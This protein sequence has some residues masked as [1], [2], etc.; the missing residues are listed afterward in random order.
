MRAGLQ[1]KVVECEGISKYDDPIA[2]MRKG[3][4]MDAKSGCLALFGIA[5]ILVGGLAGSG[6]AGVSVNIGIGVAPPAYVVPAPPPVV[7]IPGTR[8]LC[9]GARRGHP[10]LSRL[11]VPPLR[12]LLVPV[13]VVQRPMGISNARQGPPGARHAPAGLSERTPWIPAHILRRPAQ[14]LGKVGEGEVLE[15]A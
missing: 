11:L 2:R 14:E 7:P 10:F 3:D 4:L 9:P 13:T 6:E 12:R 8:L 5:A 15:K 1:A